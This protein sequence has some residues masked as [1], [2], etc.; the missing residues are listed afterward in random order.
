MWCV[1]FCGKELQSRGF[2]RAGTAVS[3]A[4][5]QGSVNFTWVPPGLPQATR[6][7]SW[8]VEASLPGAWKDREKAGAFSMVSLASIG[9]L[10]QRSNE[11]KDPCAAL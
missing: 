2:E 7:L 11:L 3:C 6:E 10:P 9:L 1:L 8:W 5:P 4:P